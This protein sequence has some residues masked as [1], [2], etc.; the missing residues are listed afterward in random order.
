MIVVPAIIPKNKEQML[1]E[2]KKVSSFA[3]LIQIDISDGIFT[4]FK[5]WPFNGQD[6]DYFTKL[7][8]EEEGL[9]LWDSIDYEFHLMIKD[10]EEYVE[11]FIH[12]GAKTII[13]Q[14]EAVNDL[15]RIINL[16]KQNEVVLGIALKPKTDLEKVTK[17]A[18]KIDFIQ[19]MGSD[20]LG[21]H[22][23]ELDQRA[24]DKI[25]ELQKLYPDKT[26][27]VDIGVNEETRNI[28]VDAGVDKLVSGSFILDS[29]SPKSADEFLSG[30]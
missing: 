6:S 3:E 2:I 1:E 23:V 21:K 10:P 14:I 28:L 22:G 27:A 11:S 12:A 16:C 8:T 7:K 17:V 15:D 29:K 20:L 30:E 19:M 9:P 18:D 25:K 13:V 24:V 5:T 4:P 26:I